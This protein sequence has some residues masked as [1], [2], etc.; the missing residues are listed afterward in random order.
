MPFELTVNDL[1]A[2]LAKAK[3]EVKPSIILYVLFYLISS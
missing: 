3:K 1:E 2:A